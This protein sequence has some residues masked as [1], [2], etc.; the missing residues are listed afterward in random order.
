[1]NLVDAALILWCAAGPAAA[2]ETTVKEV[3]QAAERAS[4]DLE[5]ASAREAQARDAVEFGKSYYYPTLDAEG[6]QSYGFQGSNG[7]LGLGGIMSSP[8]RSGPTGGLVSRM[9]LFDLSRGYGIKAARSRLEAA[10]AQTRVVRSALDQAALRIYFEGAR[11]RGQMEAWQEIGAE[12]SKVLTEVERLVRTGQHSPVERL[13]VQDQVDDAAMTAAAFAKRYEIAL[14]RL[15]LLTG[16]PEAGLACPSPLSASESSLAVITPG[17]AS[18]AVER[19]QAE[20]E[21][22]RTVVGQRGAANYPTI[23]A[24]GSA[25][26]MDKVKLVNRVDY[27]AG[28]AVKLPLFEGFRTASEISAAKDAAAERGSLVLAAKLDLDEAN[29]SYDETIEASRVKLG[30]LDRELDNAQEAL[31]LAK[32]RYLSFEGPLVDVRESIRNLARVRALRNDVKADLLLA[33]GSKAVLNGGTVRSG[34]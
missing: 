1:M 33:L 14:K 8:F 32:K 24:L 6:I 29:A 2:S 31:D 12:A 5:A 25:G 27:S 16:L 3:L 10:R 19:A 13:L 30:F 9:T 15:A 17:A 28:F 22:A 34:H 4:P 7:A 18:P 20:A 21:A 11:D 26:G 23:S